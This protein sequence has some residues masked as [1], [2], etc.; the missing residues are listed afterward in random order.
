MFQR[1][2]DFPFSL[3]Q[4]C[5]I[6]VQIGDFVLGGGYRKFELASCNLFVE[7]T[8]EKRTAWLSHLGFVSLRFSLFGDGEIKSILEYYKVEP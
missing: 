3:E 6:F 5:N 7:G 8:E 2:L 4:L 1:T